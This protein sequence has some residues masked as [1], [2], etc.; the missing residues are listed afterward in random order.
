MAPVLLNPGS[1]TVEMISPYQGGLQASGS[2]AQ[3]L[4]ANGGDVNVLKPWI[5]KDGYHYMNKMVGGELKA[6]RLG[7]AVAT[8]PKEAWLSLDEEVQR[9]AMPRMRFVS[10]LRQRGL[11]RDLPNGMATIMLQYQTRTGITPATISMD[12]MRRS[13]RDRPTFDLRNLPIPIIHK[14]FSYSLR[15][16]LASRAGNQPLDDITAVEAADVCAVEAEKLALG[17]AASY[18]YGGGSVYGVLNHPSRNTQIL[19][20]PTDPAWTG[21]TILTELLSMIQK[22]ENDGFYGPYMVFASSAWGE[23]LE[24]DYSAAVPGTSVSD[25]LLRNRRIQGIEYLDYLGTGFTLVLID[26][27]PTVIREVVGM[28]IQTIQWQTPDGMALEYK[29][30]CILVPQVRADPAGNCGIVHGAAA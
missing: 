27:R 2:I 11:T 7:N 23:F 14:D 22:A 29:V 10:M 4:L 6:V 24:N 5:G 13:E 18:S 21:N 16:V 19:T 17:V 28:E 26:M 25:R 15:E 9:A 3:L 1:P 8:L 30:M 20:A 12:G